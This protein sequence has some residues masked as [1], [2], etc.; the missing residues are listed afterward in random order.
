MA[1]RSDHLWADSGDDY[2]PATDLV[3]SMFAMTVLLLAMFGASDHIR[4]IESIDT[5]KVDRKQIEGLRTDV[6]ALKAEN[7]DLKLQ[8]EKRQ[9]LPAAPQPRLDTQIKIG[10]VTEADVGP[11]MADDVQFSPAVKD[12]I[13]AL[14]GQRAGDIATLQANRLIF[15]IATSALHGATEDGVDL[16]MTET[17]NWGEALMRTMRKSPLPVGC[18]AVLPIG[19]LHAAHL[20]ALT[21][22]P[23]AG[24][25]LDDFESL[26]TLKRVPISIAR[27]L[28][29]AKSEDRRITIWAQRVALGN[30]DFNVLV[31][32][33][34]NLRGLR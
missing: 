31:S 15:E 16:D 12:R 6:S 10:N 25:A 29:L 7:L 20:R 27:E 17:M 28:N 3:F 26:L 21:T 18:L 19:K 24:K 30:C 5:I 33:V 9:P 14:I 2:T 11:F 13:L 23:G 22:A 4:T 34:A 8:N 32:S 1:R